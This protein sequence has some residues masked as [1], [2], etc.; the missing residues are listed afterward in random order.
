MR[1]WS[2]GRACQNENLYHAT[3]RIAAAK[4]TRRASLGSLIEG[5]S[6]WRV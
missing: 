6:N 3:M 2:A 1:E 4:M 5:I